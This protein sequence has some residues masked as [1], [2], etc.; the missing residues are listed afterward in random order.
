VSSACA[1]DGNLELHRIAV[2]DHI[3]PGGDNMDL[4]LAHVV[5]GKLAAQD[6]PLDPWQ[7]RALTHGCR[8]AKELLLVESEHD[9]TPIVVPSRSSRLIGGSIRTELTR[10]EVTATLVEGLFPASGPD[11]HPQSV[12]GGIV[13]FGLPYVA[14]P[15]VTRHVAS[16]LTRHENAAREA[17][18]DTAPPPEALPVPD[19]V[20]LNGGVLGGDRERDLDTDIRQR[21]IDALSARKAPE[22][23]LKMV[24]QVIELSEA[25]ERRAFGESLPPGLMLI[26]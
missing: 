12:H 14:D 22:T 9:V 5:A 24:S 2:G 1:K 25:D 6:T 23:W 26:H 16:F 10:Q 4:A 17:L 11:E 13:E 8:S 15:A 19:A 7:I 20:L 3:L 21:V 18:G